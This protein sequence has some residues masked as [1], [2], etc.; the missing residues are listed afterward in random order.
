MAHF[1]PCTESVTAEEATLFL[2]G[3]SRL[4][5]LPRVLVSDREPKFDSGFWQT[6]CPELV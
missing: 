2:H 4:Y 3:V 5:G 6:L 1:M